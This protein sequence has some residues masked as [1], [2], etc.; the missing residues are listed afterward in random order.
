M[1]QGDLVKTMIK[2]DM[3]IVLQKVGKKVWNVLRPDGS[4]TTEWVLNLIPLDD[5]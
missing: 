1:K 5:V 3:V 2:G 4:I